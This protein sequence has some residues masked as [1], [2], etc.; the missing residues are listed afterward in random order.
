MIRI[1]KGSRKRGVLAD[2]NEELLFRISCAVFP[3][4]LIMVGVFLVYGEQLTSSDFG[5]LFHKVTGFYCPGCGGTRAFNFMIHFHFVESLLCNPFVLYA[6]LV[7]LVFMINTLMGKLTGCFIW[8]RMPV[9]PM[10]YIGAGLLLGQCVIRNIL[11]GA[12][13]ITYL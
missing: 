10:I 12:F 13:H 6:I 9:F 7:Y 11:F 8:K 4:L 1:G 5:C 3:I 2:E